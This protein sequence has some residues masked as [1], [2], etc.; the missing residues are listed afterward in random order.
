MRR[1][2]TQV[3]APC[4]AT[5][6][7]LGPYDAVIDGLKDGLRELR[8][9]PGKDVLLEVRDAR[10]DRNAVRRAAASSNEPEWT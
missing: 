8:L 10:G 7:A 2:D 1:R 6:G 9:E 3:P 4:G 5:G